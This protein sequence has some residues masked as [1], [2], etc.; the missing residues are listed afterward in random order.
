MSQLGIKPENGREL[1][2]AM[3]IKGV[4]LTHLRLIEFHTIGKRPDMV[5]RHVKFINR[6]LGENT[7]IKAHV[8]VSYLLNIWEDCKIVSS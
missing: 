5:K 8:S 7:F 2:P 1:K 3:Q 6:L 4:I